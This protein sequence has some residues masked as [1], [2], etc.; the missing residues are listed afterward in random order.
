MSEE[1]VAATGRTIA[2]S[3]GADDHRRIYDRHR[4]LCQH[5][6][7]GGRSGTGG[8][9]DTGAERFLGGCPVFRHGGDNAHPVEPISDAG[10]HRL[11]DAGSRAGRHE[12]GWNEFP[13]G[14][15]S[16]HSRRAAHVPHRGV[17]AAHPADRENSCIRC[18]GHAGRVAAA[19]LPERTPGTS[20]EPCAGGAGGCP[21]S[22]RAAV[23]SHA[24]DAACRRR[25]PRHGCGRRCNGAGVLPA[26]D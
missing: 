17:P 23:A 7:A 1:E 26:L 3:A 16:V 4:R 25:R 18:F 6:I 21:L 22:G 14:A 19:L 2:P 5:H 13:R 20:G 12:R 15:G 9:C 24:G 11:V 8:R 10:D